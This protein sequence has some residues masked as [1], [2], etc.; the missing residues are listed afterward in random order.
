[1]VSGAVAGA[2]AGAAIALTLPFFIFAV[3]G[4]RSDLRLRNAL[5]GGAMFIL[6]ALVLESTLHVFILKTNLVTSHFL[7]SNTLAFALYGSFAAGLFEETGRLIGLKFLCQRVPGLGT[8]FAYGIG[9]GG[10]E[11][12]MVALAILANLGLGYL[13]TT[14]QLD[15]L[16]LPAAATQKLHALAPQLTAVFSN[17]DFVAGMM[18]GLERIPAVIIQIALSLLVWRTVIGKGPQYYLL[19]ILCHAA[20]DFPAT[21]F[22]RH[23]LPITTFQLEAGVWAVGVVFLVLML[24]LTRRRGAP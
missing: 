6:F 7:A 19:A 4:K 23:A 17:Q 10:A 1:M 21:L 14:G 2:L 11:S 20:V 9:H 22:Q 5:V 13:L 16:R 15:A 12:I 8:P 24:W 3:I 18:G